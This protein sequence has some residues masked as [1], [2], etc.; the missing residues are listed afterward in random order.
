MKRTLLVAA[1][2]CIV[3]GLSALMGYVVVHAIVTDSAR[4][5]ALG[6]LAFPAGLA[7]AHLAFSSRKAVRSP[8]YLGV[9]AVVAG[10][11]AAQAGPAVA[12]PF[13]SFLLGVLLYVLGWMRLR[14]PTA[15]RG[16]SAQFD[17][18]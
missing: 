11:V 18:G 1:A 2:L 10:I 5:A 7:L 15:L 8:P 9:L 13:A 4:W 17:D 3:A 14:L 12:I 6:V 16:R